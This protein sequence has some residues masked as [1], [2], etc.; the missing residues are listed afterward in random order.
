MGG[1]ELEG[2]SPFPRRLYPLLP[3]F[4]GIALG[5]GTRLLLKLGSVHG[6]K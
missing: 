1:V 3:S 4:P 2:R 6:L 5:S